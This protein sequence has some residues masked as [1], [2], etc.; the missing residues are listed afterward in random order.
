MLFDETASGFSRARGVASSKIAGVDPVLAEWTAHPARRRPQDVAL[1]VAVVCVTAAA[2][3]VSFASAFLALLA[4]VIL[5]VAVAP[6]L[7]PTRYVI[8]DTAIAAER[9]FRRRERRFA[10]LRRVDIGPAAAL[11]S[12]FAHPHPLDRA[13][14]LIVFFDGGDRE[15][16][17][18]LLRER[19]K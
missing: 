1:V 12:P 11:V 6:F 15:R 4:A 13:R 8:T 2:V 7:L 5:V 16:V 10:D 18:A 9:A 19:V 14:G 17:V 3:L